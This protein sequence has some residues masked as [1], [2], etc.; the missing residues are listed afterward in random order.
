MKDLGYLKY[1]L[2]IE[3]ACSKIPKKWIYLNQRKYLLDILDDCG[4]SGA[5]PSDSPM[6]QNLKLTNIDGELISDHSCYRRLV[7]RLIYL[8]ITR[9]D[10]SYAVNILSQFMN[11]PRQPHFDVVTRLLRYLKG[12]P[13]QEILLSAQYDILIRAYCDSDWASCPDTRL[14]YYRLLYITW[15]KSH[16]MENKKII[17]YFEIIS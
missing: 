1:F 10:I 9:P 4:L 8:T 7:G 13:G 16:F 5:R 6:E 11:R 12:T 3:V 14:L 15:L 2:G 17:Y